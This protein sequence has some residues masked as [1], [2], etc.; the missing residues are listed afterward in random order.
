MNKYFR[1]RLT[2]TLICFSLVVSF[3]SALI[4]YN[5]L[6]ETVRAAHERRIKET[7]D[8][9]VDSLSTIDQ[10]Y[11]LT[12]RTNANLM[13]EKTKILIQKYEEDANFDHWDFNALKNEFG[14][15]IFIINEENIVE[16]SSL[17]PD[18]GMDFK[19]C[20][21]S[22]A[23]VLDRRRE[24]KSFHHD[25]MDTQQATGEIRT[26]SYMPTPDGKYLIELSMGI[27]ND[28]FFKQFNFLDR[29][30]ALENEYEAID[31]IYVYSRSGY[32]LG[33]AMMDGTEVKIDEE[34]RPVFLE[35]LNTGKAKDVVEVTPQGKVTHRYIPY[36]DEKERD[37][38]V[39]RVVKII[40]NEVELESLLK[41]Y[42]SSFINRQIFILFS[43]ILLSMIIARLIAQPIHLA[44]HDSLTG[45]KNRAAFEAELKRLLKK[46]NSKIA[47]MMI[48]IDNFKLVNDE[49]GH[50][51][52][53]L[54][55][56]KTAE[57]IRRVVGRNGFATRLG[58]DEFVVIFKNIKEDE[59][60]KV[61]NIL[62]KG[63]SREENE[64]NLSLSIGIA[65]A[66]KDEELI[67]LYEKADQALYKSKENGKNQYTFY[68]KKSERI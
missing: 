51:K 4:D 7:G 5:E 47:L 30:T 21:T 32:I 29:I 3:V 57:K 43:I 24:G 23:Q 58:G 19:E 46:K 10:I 62:L 15:D 18:I 50:I 25:G 2:F 6:K 54:I 64:I 44:F 48:D 31:T 52:G 22:F 11:R 27:E 16:Y 65:Y 55:L 37:Y 63:V 53:D 26:F 59:L 9:I 8:K 1:L 40:Y 17:E 68:Q 49:L 39:K 38:P 14:M 20:C 67:T 12:D 36:T 13:E 34:F 45:L 33:Y 41:F 42:K 60:S 56:M 66:E 28:V 61:S 35:A